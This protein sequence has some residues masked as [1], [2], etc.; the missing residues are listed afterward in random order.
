METKFRP[1]KVHQGFNNIV[2][3]GIIS[4]ILDEIML[5]LLW[6][7]GKPSLTASLEIS[8]KKPAMVGETL[9]FKAK[10]ERERKKLIYTKAEAYLEDGVLIAEARAKC[11]RMK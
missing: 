3:G 1:E 10:I 9:I 11:F 7:I 2:H 4:L 6:R 8:F 5:N